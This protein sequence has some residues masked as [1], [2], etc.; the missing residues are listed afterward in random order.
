LRF[1]YQS[2]PILEPDPA[3]GA[4]HVYRPVIPIRL[5]YRHR[6]LVRYR[7]RALVDSGA[8]WCLFHAEVGELVGIPVPQG[9]PRKFVGVEGIEQTAFF[10]EVRLVVGSAMV[11]IRAGFIAGFRFPYGLL[12]QAG[13]FDRFQVTLRNHPDDPHILVERYEA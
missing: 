10:H 4:L 9:K 8:D 12:G 1:P 3:T 7:Y 6:E 5:I 11:E 2:E 13:F